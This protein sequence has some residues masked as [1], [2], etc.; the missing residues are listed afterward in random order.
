MDILRHVVVD[1]FDRVRVGLVATTSVDFGV[2]VSTELVV[3]LPQVG[4]EDFSSSKE[5]QNGDV[6]FR[7]RPGRAIKDIRKSGGDAAEQSGAGA[8]RAAS[9]QTFL[10]E[11]PPIDGCFETLGNGLQGATPS[12]LDQL[13][14]VRA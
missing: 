8:E 5:T 6:A 1:A 9:N 7:Q 13:E 3:L 2:L 11:R 10:Y 12:W 4:F 14:R